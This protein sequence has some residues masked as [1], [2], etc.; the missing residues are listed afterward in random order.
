MLMKFTE[1]CDIIIV[2]VQEKGGDILRPRCVSVL[3]EKEK[4]TKS[5]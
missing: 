2:I 1:Y 4:I 3:G 5:A